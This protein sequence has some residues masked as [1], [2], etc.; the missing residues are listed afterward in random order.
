[1]PLSRMQQLHFATTGLDKPE[2][3]TNAM[4]AFF[5]Q[6]GRLTFKLEQWDR[7]AAIG[8]HPCLGKIKMNPSAFTSLQF[9]HSP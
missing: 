7:Q 2:P 9:Q 4:R 3:A 6:T 8:T 1:M 5:G